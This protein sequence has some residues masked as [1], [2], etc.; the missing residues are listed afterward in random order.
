[1]GI[2]ADSGD[3]DGPVRYGDAADAGGMVYVRKDKG[4]KGALRPLQQ[5]HHVPMHASAAA[6]VSSRF[7]DL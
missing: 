3:G 5:L 1:M 7:A 2:F 4:S 6:G